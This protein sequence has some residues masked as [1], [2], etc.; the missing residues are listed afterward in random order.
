VRSGDAFLEVAA[1]LLEVL[2]GAC[3]RERARNLFTQLPHQ[4][5]IRAGVDAGFRVLNA[6]Q[7]QH[8]A[9]VD[10]RHRRVLNRLS[11]RWPRHAATTP[12]A[13]VPSQ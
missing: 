6:Q 3:F 13:R 10:E 2:E 12:A 7:A 4:V 11:S 9:V 8:D 5:K 1:I